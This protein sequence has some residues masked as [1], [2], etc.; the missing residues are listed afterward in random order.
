MN[1]KR[2]PEGMF[3]NWLNDR[4]VESEMTEADLANKLLLTRVSVSNHIRG[5]VIPRLSTLELYADYFGVPW[6]ILYEMAIND[7]K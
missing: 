7:S 4:L 6:Y 2:K 1:S 3:A 5:S